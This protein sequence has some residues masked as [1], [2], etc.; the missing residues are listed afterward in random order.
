MSSFV[1]S[2]NINKSDFP[3]IGSPVEPIEPSNVKFSKKGASSREKKDFKSDYSHYTKDVSRERKR[4]TKLSGINSFTVNGST[5]KADFDFEKEV[6]RT[7]KFMGMDID[8]DFNAVIPIGSGAVVVANMAGFGTDKFKKEKSNSIKEVFKLRGDLSTYNKAVDIINKMGEEGFRKILTRLKCGG[9]YDLVKGISKDGKVDK[10]IY[11]DIKEYAGIV[12]RNNDFLSNSIILSIVNEKEKKKTEIN[13]DS[14]KEES[15]SDTELEE[16]IFSI[17]VTFWSDLLDY[18][19][20]VKTLLSTLDIWSFMGRWSMGDQEFNKKLESCFSLLDNTTG[21]VTNRVISFTGA[22]ENLSI[23]GQEYTGER[24]SNVFYNLGA[25]VI[26]ASNNVKK[27]INFIENEGDT[28][29]LFYGNF[30]QTDTPY[31]AEM[32]IDEMQALSSLDSLRY[33]DDSAE[34]AK[35]SYDMSDP[36]DRALYVKS[37]IRSYERNFREFKPGIN[38]DLPNTLAELVENE[39]I[40]SNPIISYDRFVGAES[41]PEDVNKGMDIVT[42]SMDEL[43]AGLNR[44]DLLKIMK[45]VNKISDRLLKNFSDSLKSQQ[46]KVTP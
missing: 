41:A 10:R 36:Y 7:Y 20:S 1:L 26:G 23:A 40:E 21:E 3:E 27:S 13:L 15:S 9:L 31:T 19:N 12:E 25:G 5:V 29:F 30:N 8:E 38:Y 39:K 28:Q 45:L 16:S 2:V 42:S 4:I 34:L 46:N 43:R 44:R 17:V 11:S 22:S 32:T 24:I 6:S 33:V 35:S 18:Y 14:Y 37:A